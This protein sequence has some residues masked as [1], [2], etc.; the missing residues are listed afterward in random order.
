VVSVTR[1][2]Q[3]LNMMQVDVE[4]AT[5]VETPEDSMDA[6]EVDIQRPNKYM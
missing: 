5:T 2:D 4:T 6:T 3:Q 1:W